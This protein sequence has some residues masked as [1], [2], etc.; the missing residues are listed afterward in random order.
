M[1]VMKTAILI[2]LVR[3]PHFANAET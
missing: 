1:G 2:F 3:F